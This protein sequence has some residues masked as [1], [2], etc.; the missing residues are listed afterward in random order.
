[1]KRRTLDIAFAIGGAIFSVLLLVLGLVLKNQADFAKS[2]VHDQ[3]AAQKITF[4]PTKSL[5]PE[6]A[7]VTCL[8]KFGQGGDPKA[9]GGQLLD[10]GKKAECYANEYI[11]AHMRSA[12]TA[13]GFEGATY[14]TMGAYTMKGDGSATSK[15]LVDQLAAA[16]TGGDQAKI[17][18]AQKAL[19][20]ATGIRGTLL[21]GET[22]RG[23][24]LTSY[25]FSV[26][27]DRAALAATICFIAFGLL[28]LLSIAGFVHAFVSKSSKDVILVAEHQHKEPVTV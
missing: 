28:L 22:L 23:L 17:D 27:G 26:F 2:Y 25:G 14:S 5:S 21:T 10:S 13:A 8:V 19:D 18:A 1:M 7:T 12:A 4:Q 9:G 3:L 15:S 24:L 6:M 16:K 20:T 11:G